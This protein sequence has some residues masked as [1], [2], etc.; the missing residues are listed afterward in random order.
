MRTVNRLLV[1]LVV[2]LSGTAL[3]PYAALPTESFSWQRYADAYEPQ[4]L[5]QINHESGQP[6]SFFKITGSGFPANS[7]ASVTVN[8][9]ELGTLNTDGMG[10]FEFELSTTN[11]DDGAYFATV[12][13]NPS[14]T[15]RFEVDSSALDMWSSEGSAN[16]F[17]VPSGIAFTEFIYL[18]VVLR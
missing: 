6:G 8:G 3:A 5:L 11:A 4:P 12:S 15:V 18:P 2:F 17:Q 9:A 14:A 10:G 16:Q 7:T 1:A 13:V